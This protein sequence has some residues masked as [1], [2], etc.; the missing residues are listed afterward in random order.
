MFTRGFAPV[1]SIHKVISSRPFSPG[2]NLAPPPRLLTTIFTPVPRTKEL[3][4]SDPPIKTVSVQGHPVSYC[5]TGPT[6]AK[7]EK[8]PLTV[9]ALHGCPGSTFDYRYIYIYTS[10]SGWDGGKV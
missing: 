9:L 6:M 2:L 4:T 5:D 7:G 8:M 10:N 3:L 1:Q